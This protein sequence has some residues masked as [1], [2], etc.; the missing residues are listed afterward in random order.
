MRSEDL[1]AMTAELFAPFYDVRDDAAMDAWLAAHNN[2]VEE[3]PSLLETNAR[4]SIKARVLV[5]MLIADWSLVPFEF[6]PVNWPH[7]FTHWRLSLA[8]VSLPLLE[9][10][11]DL[12]HLYRDADIDGVAFRLTEL[13]YQL[14]EL[15]ERLPAGDCRDKAFA[16]FQRNESQLIFTYINLH[17]VIDTRY[18]F[19][20]CL[21]ESPG[22]DDT[23]KCAA[24]QQ[25]R[26]LVTGVIP[27]PESVLPFIQPSVSEYADV[28]GRLIGRVE[29]PPYSAE[30]AEDQIRFLLDMG[31]PGAFHFFFPDRMMA[32][33]QVVRDPQLRHRLAKA[34][35][36]GGLECSRDHPCKR[37]VIPA[38]MYPLEHGPVYPDRSEVET[39]YCG[40]LT[41]ISD[42]GLT[43]A[44]ELLE[45]AAGNEQMTQILGDIITE[46]QGGAPLEDLFEQRRLAHI[47]DIVRD[48]SEQ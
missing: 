40:H 12:I 43:L 37:P 9:M 29:G 47:A 1:R 7:P 41:A 3:L 22:I 2:S 20:A 19:F 38:P 25:L 24:D 11:V 34:Y 48:M 42:I 30:L 46:I 31:K 5:V 39:D 4:M 36:L 32:A 6:K 8:R 15:I 14:L 23:Y 13:R 18:Q 21:M 33:L 17:D 44:W 16:E 45:A 28:V 10:L 26:D 27:I 35:V